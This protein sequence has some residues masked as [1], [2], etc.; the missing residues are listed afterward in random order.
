[1]CAIPLAIAFMLPYPFPAIPIPKTVHQNSKTDT[2]ARI[3]H[4]TAYVD[5]EW[6]DRITVLCGSSTESRQLAPIFAVSTGE[7]RGTDPSTPAPNRP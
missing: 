6:H 4:A 3:S 5:E 1:M 2:E 7:S